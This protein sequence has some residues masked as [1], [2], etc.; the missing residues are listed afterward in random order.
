MDAHVCGR[1][2][3][4]WACH[5]DY[6]DDNRCRIPGCVCERSSSNAE[7]HNNEDAREA[8]AAKDARIRELEAENE[9]LRERVRR[10]QNN[11]PVCGVDGSC[12][13]PATVRV[14]HHSPTAYWYAVACEHHAKALTKWSSERL[15]FSDIRAVDAFLQHQVNDLTAQ[16]KK[17]TTEDAANEAGGTT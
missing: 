5:T 15:S 3:H 2:G 6:L 1:C 11:E 10:L 16:L 12:P 4:P 14:R 13:C 9:R 7:K 17:Y 8:I